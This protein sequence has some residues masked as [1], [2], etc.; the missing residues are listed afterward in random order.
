[1]P[2]GKMALLASSANNKLTF[3]KPGESSE[4][5]KFSQKF[6]F[7]RKSARKSTLLSKVFNFKDSN[8]FFYD[9]SKHFTSTNSKNFMRNSLIFEILHKFERAEKNFAV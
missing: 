7:E 3:K 8:L 1:L 5:G 9:S 6:V 2:E 4:E